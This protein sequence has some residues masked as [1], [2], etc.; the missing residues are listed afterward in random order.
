MTSKRRATD[1]EILAGHTETALEARWALGVVV[2]ID[3]SADIEK[4]VE[5]T[6][7]AGLLLGV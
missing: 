1:E 7:L 3:W 2:T 6:E 5:Q 4:V